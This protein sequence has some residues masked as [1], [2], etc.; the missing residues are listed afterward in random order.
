LI[1]LNEEIAETVDGV[2]LYNSLASVNLVLD[3]VCETHSV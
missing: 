3:Q 2:Q 1:K